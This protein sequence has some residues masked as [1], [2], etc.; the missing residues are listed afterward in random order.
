LSKYAWKSIVSRPG[1]EVE[2]VRQ[3]LVD[4]EIAA[5]IAKGNVVVVAG[6]ANLAALGTLQTDAIL[7]VLAAAPGAKVLPAYRRGNIV[8]AVQVGMGPGSG[9][10]STAKILA[11]AAAG[12]VKC[13]VLLGADLVSDFPDAQAVEKALSSGVSIIAVDTFLSPTAQRAH[14]V[15]AASGA[16]EKNGTV[17]NIEGRVQTV[18]QKVN[19]AG[20]SRPDWMIATELASRLGKD[21]G[22]TS[23]ESVTE[24]IAANVPA[25]AGITPAA[26][27]DARDG[28]L[29][30]PTASSALQESGQQ[31]PTASGYDYRL[32]VT[33]ELY[34]L[35]INNQM[36]PS[37]AGLAR[38]MR[39]HMNPAD[40]ERMGITDGSTVRVTTE[41]G[42]KDLTVHSDA[43]L[44]RWTVWMPF[45]QPGGSA[46]D[47]ISASGLVADARIET[48]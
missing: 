32:L 47:L 28:L 6:K 41:R 10:N 4:P 27:K 22:F 40:L 42:S 18:A 48:V 34:D 17:T 14:V 35:G 45:N 19:V 2:A 5:Q 25:Y 3:A 8:G 24:A 29:A 21:L 20:T 38:G 31:A 9:G 16:G 46:N 11:D 13:L 43:G 7:K 37:L 39:V 33:R 30:V 26:L 36:S 44:A 15:L 23:V 1:D 12:T